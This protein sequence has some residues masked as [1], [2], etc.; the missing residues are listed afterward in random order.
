MN[1]KLSRLLQP[2]LGLYFAAMGVFTLLAALKE[3]YALAA[4]EA[5]ITLLLLIFYLIRKAARR[6]ELQ[7]F[8]RSTADVLDEG[9]SDNPFP[10]MMVRLGDNEVIWTNDEFEEISGFKENMMEQDVTEVLPGFSM[11]WIVSNKREYPYDVT[12][13][14]RRYRIYG[15]TVRAGETVLALLYFADLTELYQ[16]RDEYIRS[17]PVVSI[18]LIDN[19]EELTKNMTEGGISAMNAKL[20][21]TITAWTESYHGMLRKL[22]RSRSVLLMFILKAYQ[23]PEKRCGFPRKRKIPS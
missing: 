7:A 23:R 21:D 8:I 5:G 22:D 3:Q 6:R 12:L 15:N 4:V 9:R 18:I 16:I 20:N 19:Y 10:M 11:D 1:K 2:G 13:G 17:R 14:A